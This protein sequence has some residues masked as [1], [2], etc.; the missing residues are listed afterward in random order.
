M[1][2]R[3][4]LAAA[5]VILA[6]A[7]AAYALFAV[8]VMRDVAR[9][10]GPGQV[11]RAALSLGLADAVPVAFTTSDGLTIRGSFVPARNGATV[12]LSHGHGE[13]RTQMLPEARLLTRHNFGALLFDWRA[14]GES[15]GTAS[16]RGDRERLDLTAAIDFLAGRA[17]VDAG[18]LGVLGFSRGGSVAIAVAA[19]DHRL[20]G[21][22][23]EAA[24]PSLREA[25]LRDV[26]GPHMLARWPALWAARRA[27]IDIDGVQPEAA[28][29]SL[30]PR[31]ILI[32]QG[33]RDRVVPVSDA[34]RLYAAARQP[35]T[36]WLI[37]GADHGGYM[38]REPV[39]YERRLVA[40]FTGAL[41]PR[42]V[43]ESNPN[44]GVQSGPAH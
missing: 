21:V 36:L 3:S 35:K 20:R 42:P 7:L 19:K 30:S 40:F 4:G 5:L 39:E 6:L 25:L 41:A 9:L 27:G 24:A 37:Q 2:V 13:D 18:R 26:R 14:H 43:L 16:T 10:M 8:S 34:H 22:V 28:I 23:A 15:E 38:E 11:G 1:S 29:S 33:A 32:I 31:P 12:I 44:T 17:D